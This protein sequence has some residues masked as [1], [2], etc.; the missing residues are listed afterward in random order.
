M[1][2]EEWLPYSS[3]PDRFNRRSLNPNE[4]SPRSEASVNKQKN[5]RDQV[6]RY[7]AE[8]ASQAK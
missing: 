3:C 5:K 7:S 4:V 2:D 8:A 6:L 1:T